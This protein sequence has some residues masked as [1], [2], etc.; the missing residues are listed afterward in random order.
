MHSN[1][2]V[3]L[4]QVATATTART[5]GSEVWFAD[6]M[7]PQYTWIWGG[8]DFFAAAAIRYHCWRHGRCKSPVKGK[9][10][11][12][13]KVRPSSLQ[14]MWDIIDDAAVHFGISQKEEGSL[15]YHSQSADGKPHSGQVLPLQTGPGSPAGTCG[16]DGRQFCPAQWPEKYSDL[17]SVTIPYLVLIR[18]R[19]H[20]PD[21]LLPLP[22]PIPDRPPDPPYY[23]L[24][25][26]TPPPPPRNHRNPPRFHRIHL[27]STGFTPQSHGTALFNL[28][29]IFHGM[30][31][32]S[33]R[34]PVLIS[35][36][37]LVRRDYAMILYTTIP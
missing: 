36:N 10:D 5:Y 26:I 30:L 37:R 14:K 34:G 35:R 16:A 9:L 33:L 11:N 17:P 25:S 1:N 4:M 23:S 2:V 19:S 21:P 28:A 29:L 22:R 15:E 7:T 24:T 3:Q 13:K 6:E 32:N 18:Y 12:G 8:P 31:K 27:D 20:R